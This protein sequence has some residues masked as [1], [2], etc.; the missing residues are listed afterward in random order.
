MFKN[1][2]RSKQKKIQEIC[3]FIKITNQSSKSISKKLNILALLRL[4]SHKK[5]PLLRDSGFNKNRRKN[6]KKKT[7]KNC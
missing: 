7:K 6:Y 5:Y 4:L 3:L 2:F 1:K